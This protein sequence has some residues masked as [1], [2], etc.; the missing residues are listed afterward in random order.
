MDG[1]FPQHS[2]R[3]LGGDWR[4]KRASG[5]LLTTNT[6]ASPHVMCTSKWQCI[7]QAPALIS[8]DQHNYHYVQSMIHNSGQL[9]TTPV[10]KESGML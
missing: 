6:M 5:P 10:Q 1:S 7:T 2:G 9:G 8:N 4:L 3:S